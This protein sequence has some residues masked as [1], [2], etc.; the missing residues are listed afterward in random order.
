MLR[1]VRRIYPPYLCAVLFFF[2]TRMLK[3]AVGAGN[4]ISSSLAVWIQNLTLTQ[5]V[6]LLFDPRSFPS[7]NNNL[8][9]AA[10]WSLNY[11]EQFYL[12]M[13]IMAAAALS[14]RLPIHRS[15]A[16]LA[17]PC[18]LWNV[19]HPAVSYGLFIEYW[20][21]FAIGILVY[22]RLCSPM[23]R[24]M[25]MAVDAGLLV[26][27]L[28]SLMAWPADPA[29]RRSVYMEWAVV[30]LFALALILFRRWDAAFQQSRV[31]RALGAFGVITYS[32]YLTHQF[33]LRPSRFLAD[34]LVHLGAPHFLTIPLQVGALLVIAVVFW[35]F[36]ERPFLNRPM[37]KLQV[38]TPGA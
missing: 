23:S 21:H 5:W 29:A 27:A 11:E 19:T 10:F 20:V 33:N 6:H 25:T 4:Q 13:A 32:L 2:A 15:A 24:L 17:L 26:F 34:K 28:V 8:F 12:L 35:Y 36:C 30:S 1:R 38:D 14:F 16:L 22:Y 3:L 9:V 37:Q 31:G 7:E 18:F